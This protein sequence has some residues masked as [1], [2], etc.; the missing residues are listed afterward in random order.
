MRTILL[1]HLGLAGL[2][3]QHPRTYMAAWRNRDE[4]ELRRKLNE[5]FATDQEENAQN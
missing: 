1:L 4:L 3:P 5:I 2:L